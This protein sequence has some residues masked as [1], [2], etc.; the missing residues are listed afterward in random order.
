M[1]PDIE[2]KLLR[3]L[4]NFFA[5]QQRMPTMQELEIKTGRRIEDIQAGLLSLER[6]K[7]HI[8][9]RSIIA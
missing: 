9:M 4:Y 8:I 7:M 1:L 6:D 5:Q 2:R 3:M